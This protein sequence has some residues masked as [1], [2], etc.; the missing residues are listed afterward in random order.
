[1]KMRYIVLLVN[2][3]YAAGL[4]KTGNRLARLAKNCLGFYRAHFSDSVVYDQS[5]WDERFYG[6]TILDKNTI[7]P[8]IDEYATAY[9]Y[10]SIELII[11]K[12][13]FRLQKFV[14]PS[15][16]LDVGTGAGHWINFYQRIGAKKLYGIDVSKKVIDSLSAKY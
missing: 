11:A 1:M 2:I 9:H 14:K 7:C 15:A 10:A 12:E 4:V 16:V 13:L 6:S 5:W 8:S 3:F